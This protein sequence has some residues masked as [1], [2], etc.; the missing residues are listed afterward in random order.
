MACIVIRARDGRVFQFSAPGDEDT[1]ARQFLSQGKG[2][3]SAD[4]DCPN[5]GPGYMFYAT[6]QHRGA[7]GMYADKVVSDPKMQELIASNG[8]TQPTSQQLETGLSRDAKVRSM[9]GNATKGA[10]TA[11]VAVTAPSA[12]TWCLANPVA[13]N[14][15]VIA[16]GEI[17]ASEA[18]GP[19]ALGVVGTASAVKAVRSANEV[20]AAMVARGWEPGWRRCGR[21]DSRFRGHQWI[22]GEK[23]HGPLAA[24]LSAQ[25]VA[26][27]AGS[28]RC[29]AARRS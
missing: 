27:P 7:L 26:T 22:D 28:P 4:P 10:A 11:A 2:M 8:I 17:A 23:V 18:L 12:L 14:R 19:V 29:H 6:P 20:N 16:G 25:P 1:H 9:I 24:G 3:L 21:R 15:I 5:C 13:C